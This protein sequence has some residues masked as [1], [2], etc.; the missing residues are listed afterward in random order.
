M[1]RGTKA[2]P[3]RL[4]TYRRKRDFVRTPEPSGARLPSGEAGSLRFVV[5]RHRASRLHYDF[6]LELD[7]VLVSW[8]V[9]KG[10]TLDP[11]VRRGAY[12]TEDHPI[13]YLHFEG[14]IP[15]REYGGGDV[16]VWDTGTWQPE[17]APKMRDPAR[18]LAGGELHFDLYGEKLHGRF[19]LVRTSD[20]GDKEQWL[21][22]HKHD[23]FAVGGWDA[24]DHPR[25]VVSGRTN[26]EVLADPD[27]LWRSDLPAAH[28]SIELKHRD[29]TADELAEL[30]EL[31]ANGTWHVF[32]Q[33]VR[34]TNLDR[35]V[36]PPRRGRRKPVTKRDL[37]RYAARIAPVVLPHLGGRAMPI[38]Q[39][40]DW[41]SRWRGHVVVDRPAALVWLANSGRLDWRVSTARTEQPDKPTYAVVALQQDGGRWA[42]VVS[43]ARLYRTALEHLGLV[44]G[45][46]ITGDRGIE[47]WVPIEPG[48]TFAKTGEWLGSLTAVVHDAAPELATAAQLPPTSQDHL[49][50]YSPRALAGA[51]VATPVDRDEIMEGEPAPDRWAVCTVVDRV[52]DHGDPF[53][54]LSS[55]RQR[56]PDLR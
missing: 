27:R 3:D 28:A 17:D 35:E 20:A 15:A 10:P 38:S 23:D 9:P 7:G 46:L 50:P 8:A 36:A 16:I 26:D 14:V 47:I 43:V 56:L 44:S 5:Q 40:P 13:E 52:A 1:A 6:R 51:P 41:V 39:A 37:V 19:V 53:R 34:L 31:G 2:T 25:S 29:V 45:T 42:D 33:E 54:D 24:E 32:D 49:V 4:A 21:L 11:K 30:Q 55:H 48:P 18:A 12:R 22:L